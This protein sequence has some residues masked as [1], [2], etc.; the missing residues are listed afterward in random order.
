M[1]IRTLHLLTDDIQGT[2]S[3]YRDVLSLPVQEVNAEHLAVTAGATTIIFQQSSGLQ[4]K[5]HFAFNIPCNK[6]EEA[7][8]WC[9]L[10]LTILPTATGSIADFISWHAKAIYF[11]DNNYNILELIARY[12]LHNETTGPFTGSDFLSV[13]ETGIVTD[14]PVNF[15]NDIASRYDL[16]F[17]SKGTIAADF[18]TMGDD[19][20]LLIISESYRNWYPAGQPAEKHFTKIIFEEAGT[21][22]ELIVNAG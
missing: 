9:S 11:Y 1:N 16:P 3:F 13:S 12:D 15:A 7:L 21:E 17:F 5:Y 22:Y 8:A 14:H 6:I 2:A 20:G 10:R 19:N 4:P 18:V